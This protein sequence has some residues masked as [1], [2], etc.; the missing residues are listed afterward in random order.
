MVKGVLRATGWMERQGVRRGT[1]RVDKDLKGEV[2]VGR[3]WSMRR[4]GKGQFTKGRDET[5]IG[6]VHT[7]RSGKGSGDQL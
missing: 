1:V 6:V 2:C 4:E 5:V 7:L 3:E